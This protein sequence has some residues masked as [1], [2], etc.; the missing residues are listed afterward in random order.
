[1][2]KYQYR[3]RSPFLLHQ[4]LA[5]YEFEDVDRLINWSKQQRQA[6]VEL[7]DRLTQSVEEQFVDDVAEID[8]FAKL[9]A[10]CAIIALWRCVELYRKRVIAQALGRAEADRVYINEV[11]CKKLAQLGI[12]ES[13]LRCAKSVNEIRLLNNAVK[14]KGYVEGELAALPRW[15]LKS[16]QRIGDL[17]PHYVRLRPLADRYID[18]LTKMATEWWKRK[19]T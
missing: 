19:S 10:E 15:K 9:Y 5:R 7:L 4:R 13:T 8:A 16:G 17:R 3:G 1:M 6:R 14:H 2:A 11:F 12:T 18:D